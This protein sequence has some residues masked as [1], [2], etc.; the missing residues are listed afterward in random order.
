MW[1]DEHQMQEL[2]RGISFYRQYHFN[3]VSLEQ[4][5]IKRNLFIIKIYC[6]LIFIINYSC[7][8]PTR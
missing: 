1:A 6:Y 3:E 8:V 4:K 7:Q 2:R 5:V